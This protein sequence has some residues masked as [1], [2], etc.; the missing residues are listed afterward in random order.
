[1]FHIMGELEIQLVSEVDMVSSGS[2]SGFLQFF[3]CSQ[4]FNM[5]CGMAANNQVN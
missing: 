5:G 2:R 1:M 3:G 4:M